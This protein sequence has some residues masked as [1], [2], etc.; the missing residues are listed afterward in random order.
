MFVLVPITLFELCIVCSIVLQLIL[1]VPL[2]LA[3]RPPGS[4]WRPGSGSVFFL[5]V[6]LDIFF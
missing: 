5:S 6:A 1:M 4:F 3:N 2:S